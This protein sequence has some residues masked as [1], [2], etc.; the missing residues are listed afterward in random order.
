LLSDPTDPFN[1]EPLNMD[2]LKPNLELKAQIE[3]WI[4]EKLQAYESN[5]STAP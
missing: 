3:E 2:Q 5:K 1:R 4:K